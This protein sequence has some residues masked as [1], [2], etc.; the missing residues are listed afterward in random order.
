MSG[1]EQEGVG[2]VEEVVGSDADANAFGVFR[3]AGVVEHPFEIGIDVD[4][5]GIG[6]LWP[7]VQGCFDFFHGE[8]GPFDNADLNGSL[9]GFGPLGEFLENL[10]R[11][12]EIGL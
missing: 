2:D 10:I 1:A 3:T 9:A 4:F 7:V 6:C 11:V 12:G 8:I 5:V